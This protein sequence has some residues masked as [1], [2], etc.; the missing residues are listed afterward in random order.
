MGLASKRRNPND[1]RSWLYGL[2]DEGRAFVNEHIALSNE[3][4]LER[5][6]ALSEDGCKLFE[7]AIADAARALEGSAATQ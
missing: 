1:I 7:T 4:L 6:D 5:L 3:Y 2:T